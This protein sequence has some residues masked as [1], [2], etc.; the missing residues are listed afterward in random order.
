MVDA[1]ACEASDYRPASA[2]DAEVTVLGIHVGHGDLRDVVSF[3]TEHFC[4]E[5]DR[6]DSVYSGQVQAAWAVGC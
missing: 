2:V 3:H 6:E 5:L 1:I 4:N